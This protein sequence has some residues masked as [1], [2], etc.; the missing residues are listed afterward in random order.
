MNVRKPRMA[1]RGVSHVD[2]PSR[3]AKLIGTDGWTPVDTRIR[4]SAVAD[5]VSKLGGEELYGNNPSVPLR[6]LIQNASDA[7]RA[8]RVLEERDPAWGE[9]RISTGKDPHGTWIQVEDTG[10][11]MSE[12]VITGPFLD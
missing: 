1:A 10:I 2:D 8:R 7:V 4:V 6:E 3:L 12:R 5:L 11:G 9:I